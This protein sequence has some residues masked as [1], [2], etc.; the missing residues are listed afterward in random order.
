MKTIYRYTINETI[1]SVSI[2]SNS[3]ILNVGTAIV[4]N[5][6]EVVS[7]WAIVDTENTQDTRKFLVVG[8]GADLT[9]TETYN[10][11]YIGTVQRRN[12]YA[13]HVFEILEN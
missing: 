3:Q 9:A 7:I 5:G 1:N 10:L 13:F 6:K 12:K 11:K 2:P 4:G 8:T